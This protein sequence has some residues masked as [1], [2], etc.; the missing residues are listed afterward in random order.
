MTLMANDTTVFTP[1]DNF[2]SEAEEKAPQIFRPLMDSLSARKGDDE[3]MR[4]KLTI[5]AHAIISTIVR[6][7]FCVL[8]CMLSLWFLTES[9]DHRA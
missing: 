4:R 9:L 7:H 3:K 6:V 8:S 2:C 5:I 1:S